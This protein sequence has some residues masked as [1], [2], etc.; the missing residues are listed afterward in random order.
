MALASHPDPVRSKLNPNLLAKRMLASLIRDMRQPFGCVRVPEPGRPT[1]ASAVNGLLELTL[2]EA[3][4]L[5]ALSLRLWRLPR[6]LRRAPLA[7]LAQGRD[8]GH[9]PRPYPG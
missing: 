6:Q 8:R 2:D 5:E 3:R 9:A 7:G 4:T 1:G